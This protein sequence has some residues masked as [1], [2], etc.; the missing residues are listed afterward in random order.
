[1][2]PFLLVDKSFIESLSPEEL[3]FLDRHYT[4]IITPILISE[5]CADL[6]KYPRDEDTS[7]HRAA[8]LADKAKQFGAKT[9]CQFENI[10][11]ADLFGAE[12]SLSP[13]IPRI[14]GRECTAEDGSTGMVFEESF[15][16]KML[17]RWAN[18]QFTE[19]DL[20]AAKDHYEKRSYNLE[21]SGKAMADLYP[22]NAGYKSLDELSLN[23]DYLLSNSPNQ[24]NIIESLIN[25]LN[26]APAERDIVKTRWE[27]E[28]HPYFENFSSYAFFCYRLICIFWV[29]VTS[30]LI[31]T[32][33]HEKAIIDYEYF[34]Y[35]P[36][37]HAFCSNDSFH[38]NFSMFFLRSD[39]DFVWGEELKADLQAISSCYKNMTSDEKQYYEIHFGHYPPPIHNSITYFLW[40]KHMRPWTPRSGNLAIE[41]SE[42]NKKKM[43]E[44]INKIIEAYNKTKV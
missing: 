37:V 40:Q 25:I 41:M 33:K 13:I 32:S 14:G 23:I 12:V 16:D 11:I 29:G 7:K 20:A 15:E 31:P 43:A 30:G 44:E 2:G 24:W 28:N 18:R 3:D 21:S 10:C 39:Q 38:R 36:F 5:I 8:L 4:M 17:R 35:L 9:V 19:D 42:E 1:M 6:L 26:L 22:R 27:A 34:F